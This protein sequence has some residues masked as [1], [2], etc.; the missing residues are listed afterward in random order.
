MAVQACRIKPQVG[1]FF[2]FDFLV[3]NKLRFMTNLA[4][5]PRMGA[6]EFITCQIMIEGGFAEPDDLEV[7]AMVIIMTNYTFLRFYIR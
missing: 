3:L 4:F 1:V 7:P 5:F 2:G 6:L